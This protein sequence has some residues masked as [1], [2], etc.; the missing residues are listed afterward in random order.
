[1]KPA[2]ALTLIAVLALSGCG[3]VA[4]FADARSGSFAQSVTG[5]VSI[6]QLTVVDGDANVTVVTLA[7]P[8]F[9]NQ[10]RFCGN[11][12]DRFPLDSFVRVNFNPAPSC[13]SSFVVVF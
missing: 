8:G 12:V 2:L 10:L 4:F 1:M 11:V 5:S 6:V 7:Q 13:V 9:S 3:G